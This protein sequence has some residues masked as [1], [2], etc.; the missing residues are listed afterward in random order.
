MK[1][2]N[3]ERALAGDPVVTRD[4]DCVIHIMF[5]PDIYKLTCPVLYVTAF[6]RYN[7]RKDGKLYIDKDS[8]LD[9]FM[10]SVKRERWVAIHKQGDGYYPGGLFQTETAC[11]KFSSSKTK[12]GI[13]KIEWEE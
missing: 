6:G 9:L 8:S 1:P 7:V 4:G 3:L 12:V 5:V 13:A 10:A 2:F 11:Q